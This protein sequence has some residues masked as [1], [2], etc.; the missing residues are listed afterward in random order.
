MKTGIWFRGDLRRLDNP[1]VTA[2]LEGSRANDSEA[3]V[4]ALY[5]ACPKQWELHDWAPIKIDLLWRH[6]E[7][8]RQELAEFGI[9]LDIEIADDW[10]A[11]PKVVHQFCQRHQLRQLHANAEYPVHE[12][13]RDRAVSK[14]L[15]DNRCSLQLHHGLLLVPPVVK[16]QQGN[17]YQKFTPFNRAW[18][19]HL[20]LAGIAP[21]KSWNRIT[22]P[23]QLEPMPTCPGPRRDS[24]AWVVGEENCRR[25][26][27]RYVEEHVQDYDAERDFPALDTTSRLSP[28]WELGCLG[29][30]TAA[31]A[32]Q[33]LSPE[34][35]YGLEQGAD[36]WLTELA[37]REFY[38]HLMCHIP[39]LSYGKAFQQHTDAFPWRD[40]DDDF[41]RWCDGQTGFPIVD[42]G[43]RQLKHEGWMH[44]RVRMIVANFLVKDLRID[45]RKGEQYF[46]Q[47]LIDG[48]FPANNGGWQ[49]S[50]STGTDAVPYFRVFNPTR[51]SEKVDPDGS[52]IR[53]WIPELAKCPTKQI[54]APVLWLQASGSKDYPKPMVDHSEAREAFLSAFKAL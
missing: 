43:M 19:E 31:R 49:W 34:F 13:R 5:I 18:R 25:A 30:V 2:A 11:A 1:A 42:A 8:F 50:A 4:H 15:A 35:P 20:A 40:A 37:W 54:H 38:Q 14:W 26:L 53:K 51:Q 44:N 7:Q 28:Y 3:I 32:L 27:Q 9:L 33:K 22:Q 23:L 45:W 48:S 10:R 47:N 36:T 12:Q 6:L 16:T 46:M 29:P 39:R 21:L 17:V 41:Q 52:Y 24:S